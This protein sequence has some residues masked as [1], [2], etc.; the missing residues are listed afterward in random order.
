MSQ[1]DSQTLLYAAKILTPDNRMIA[2]GRIT[3]SGVEDQF[4][5]DEVID[6]ESIRT[7]KEVL[8]ETETG[9][10][11]LGDWTECEAPNARHF[12]FRILKSEPLSAL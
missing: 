12:H 1:S 5:P 8:A 3:L 11:R 10:Y 9:R 7:C 2:K 4:L 6:W